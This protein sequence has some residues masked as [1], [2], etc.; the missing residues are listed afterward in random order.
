MTEHFE[1][2]WE[3]AEKISES[4]YDKKEWEVY[5]IIAELQENLVFLRMHEKIMI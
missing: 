3:K 1:N 2:L 4:F 5:D